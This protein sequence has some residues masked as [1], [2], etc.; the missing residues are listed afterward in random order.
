MQG[1]EVESLSRVE[2]QTVGFRARDRNGKQWLRMGQL[3]WLRKQNLPRSHLLDCEVS[4]DG[5]GNSGTVLEELTQ[6][7]KRCDTV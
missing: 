3:V 1:R 5:A 4:K 2:L 6:L 7:E